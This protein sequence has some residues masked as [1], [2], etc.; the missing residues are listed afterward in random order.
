LRTPQLTLSYRGGEPGAGNDFGS[1]IFRD[2]GTAPC[3][4]AGTVTA[5]GLSAAGGPVT[6]T[7]TSTFPAGR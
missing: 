3:F 2:T 1:I 5:T 4:L 6:T 7:V